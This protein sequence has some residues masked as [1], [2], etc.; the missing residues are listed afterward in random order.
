MNKR[1][2]FL[3][4][5]MYCLTSTTRAMPDP[6]ACGYNITVSD[7][8]AEICWTDT[9]NDGIGYI[10]E[11]YRITTDI[12]TF[13]PASLNGLLGSDGLINLPTTQRCFHF[14]DELLDAD[15]S[16]THITNCTGIYV[17]LYVDKSRD[18][19]DYIGSIK[20]NFSQCYSDGGQT[21]AAIVATI[22]DCCG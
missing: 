13:D 19:K 4:F 20:I 18:V 17:K 9:C 8:E 11:Y 22:E 10:L 6:M 5:L 2:L 16:T 14:E 12:E 1:L 21:G 3:L 7:D 15:P